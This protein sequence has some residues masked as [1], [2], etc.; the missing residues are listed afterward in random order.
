MLTFASAQAMRTPSK[1]AI[2]LIALYKDD[3]EEI[4]YLS[5]L[6]S[7]A[8]ESLLRAVKNRR[9]QLYNRRGWE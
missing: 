3:A 5:S 4:I 9:I 8:K 7:N 2:R 1:I 6:S